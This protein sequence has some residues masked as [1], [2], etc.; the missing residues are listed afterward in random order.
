MSTSGRRLGDWVTE[1]LRYTDNTEPPVSYHT[2][3]AISVI[4][5]ALERRCYTEW[6]LETIYPNMY[7]VLVGPSGAAKKGTAMKIGKEMLREVGV[8]VIPESITREAFIRAL[9]ES[10]SSFSDPS[11][12]GAIRFHCS[13]TVFSEELTVFL[14]TNDVKFLS[15]LTDLYDAA[16][17]WTYQTKG[18]G[19]DRVQG[20]CVNLLGATA[21]DW[22]SAILPKEAVGGGF[23]SRIIFV[24]EDHKRKTVPFYRLT[25]EDR[26]RKEDLIA[27]LETIRTLCGEFEWEE[28]AL[29]QY[30]EWYE[31]HDLAIK[32]GRAP[33]EDPRFRGYLERKAT[34][35]R[36]LSMVLSASRS[37]SMRVEA[38]DFQRA[39]RMLEAI[40]PRMPETFVGLGGNPL[41]K[42]TEDLIRYIS[43]RGKCTRDEVLRLFFREVDAQTL[44]IVEATLS[45][46]KLIRVE[47]DGQTV[48]YEWRGGS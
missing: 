33:I 34:H 23:T 3:T 31:G 4:A 14:G 46:M 12:G 9:K 38:R 25:E 39:L 30:T 6:G 8:R 37:N 20:V 47:I 10:V 21:P 17:E 11:R 28:Q 36:K 45:E 7:I 1:Y 48:T 27:D 44:R 22:F 32:Q 41:T 16:D 19:T 13:A 2:W 24:V 42:V 5:G 26:K 40:E 18:S 43:R 35:L 29:R 15:D